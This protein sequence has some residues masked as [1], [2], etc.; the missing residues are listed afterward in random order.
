LIPLQSHDH[1]ALNVARRLCFTGHTSGYGGALSRHF[2]NAMRQQRQKY[3][4]LPTVFRS[5]KAYSG[6]LAEA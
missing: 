4:P 3:L 5:K 2:G 1:N 6:W